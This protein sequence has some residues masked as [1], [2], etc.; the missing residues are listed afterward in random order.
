MN[1]FFLYPNTKDVFPIYKIT[2]YTEDLITQHPDWIK[3]IFFVNYKLI[4]SRQFNFEIVNNVVDITRYTIPASF[5]INHNLYAWDSTKQ[6]FIISDGKYITSQA[7]IVYMLQREPQML[8]LDDPRVKIAIVLCAASFGFVTSPEEQRRP[9]GFKPIFFDFKPMNFASLHKNIQKEFMGLC[10]TGDPILITG[11]TGI[12]KTVV[13]PILVWRYDMFYTGFEYD[14]DISEA[15]RFRSSG[16]VLSVPR[17]VM[18]VNAAKTYLK[19]I[20]FKNVQDSPFNVVFQNVPPDLKNY[21]KTETASRFNI[22]VD[23]LTGIFQNITSYIFDEVHEHSKYS[24]IYISIK[25]KSNSR[26]V[27]ISATIDTELD[28]LKRVIPTLRRI[29]VE[30]PT[31]YE[32]EEYTFIRPELYEIIQMNIVPETVI[33]VFESSENK[34]IQLKRG[35]DEYLMSENIQNTQ[36]MIYTRAI[37]QKDPESTERF[38]STHDCL[39]VVATNIL[40]SS[41]T[42][43]RATVVIDFGQQYSKFFRSGITTKIN[44]SSYMQR[45]GRVGRVMN[46]K[47]FRCFDLEDL[48]VGSKII[49][50]NYL[51]DY[52]IHLIAANL[53]FECLIIQPSDLS[54]YSKTID[55][56]SR[57]GVDLYENANKIINIRRSKNCTLDEH[58]I[59]YLLGSYEEVQALDHLE[60]SFKYSIQNMPKNPTEEDHDYFT[61]DIRDVLDSNPD[62]YVS[63]ALQMDIQVKEEKKPYVYEVSKFE[64]S[65]NFIVTNKILLHE[66]DRY[67]LLPNLVV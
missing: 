50:R 46:G 7:L 16:V 56:Y 15:Q 39:V 12:G 10:K 60:E 13:F 24:D 62:I 5:H 51:L 1:E 38:T 54:R 66:H 47:Y 40:E 22:C 32:I 19:N 28:A 63:I 48:E 45:K 20:G 3:E 41:I 11:S 64:T 18:A 42:I 27:L 33:I 58:I 53:P 31:R 37:A 8:N 14:C 2:A 61:I 23:A 26:V 9:E 59:I 25:L 29:H 17:K 52:M 65:K 49:D 43:D 6:L 35:I 67:L 4:S 55:Y 57:R 36:T 44:Y 34:C 30:G 21:F